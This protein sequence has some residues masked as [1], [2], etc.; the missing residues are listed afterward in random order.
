LSRQLCAAAI[1][2]ERREP[3]LPDRLAAERLQA[4]TPITPGLT[5]GFGI[6]NYGDWCGH[7]GQVFGW[8]GDAWHDPETGVTFVAFANSDAGAS[9]SFER[10]LSEL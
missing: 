7:E 9:R 6:L 8:Q 10:L 1:N 5:Y 3:L 2:H 4:T